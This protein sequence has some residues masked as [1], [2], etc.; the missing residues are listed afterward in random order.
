M[1]L[2]TKAYQFSGRTDSP[3][4]EESAI[5]SLNR[6]FQQMFISRVQ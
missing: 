1:S 5:F 3:K 4:V 6:H 2:Q